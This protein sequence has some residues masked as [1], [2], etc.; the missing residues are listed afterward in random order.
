MAYHYWS[1]Y[2][3]S[4]F[5]PR[6]TGVGC[7][8]YTGTAPSTFN[9]ILTTSASIYPNSY[10]KIKTNNPTKKTKITVM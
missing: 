5:N 8:C 10:H 6:G 9:N 1:L 3:R 7:Y 4:A 2:R